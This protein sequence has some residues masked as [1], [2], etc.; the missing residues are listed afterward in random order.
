[1]P[2]TEIN[3]HLGI[4]RQIP[5]AYLAKLLVLILNTVISSGITIKNIPVPRLAKGLEDEH[6][7]P[8]EVTGYLVRWFGEVELDRW[9]MNREDVVRHVGLGMLTPHKVCFPRDL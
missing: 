3:V 7:I 5:L 8:E 9:D 2:S 4:L 1:V 6:Q